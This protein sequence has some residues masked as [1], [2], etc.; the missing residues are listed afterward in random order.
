MPEEKEEPKANRA[1]LVAGLA[2]FAVAGALWWWQR[3]HPCPCGERQVEDI[4][5]ASAELKQERGEGE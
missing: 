1:L 4:A 2:M 3:R 5:K